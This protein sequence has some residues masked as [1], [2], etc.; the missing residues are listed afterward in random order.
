MDP[1]LGLINPLL[2]THVDHGFKMLDQ[3]R[4]YR[5]QIR[6]THF[7]SKIDNVFDSIFLEKKVS[8]HSSFYR[9]ILAI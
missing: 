5:T 6:S 4:T 8:F 2:A 9:W 1:E 3:L 7:P